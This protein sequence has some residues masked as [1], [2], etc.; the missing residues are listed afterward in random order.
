MYQGKNISVEGYVLGAEVRKDPKIGHIWIMVIGEHPFD[1][2]TNTQLIFP[3]IE[4]KIRVGETGYNSDI[5][6]RCHEASQ[7]LKARGDLVKVYGTVSPA[8][9]MGHYRGIDLDLTAIE[10][11]GSIFDTDYDDRSRFEAKAPSVLKKIIRGGK[12]FTNL[13]KAVI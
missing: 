6:E 12:K 2:G 8:L 7:K 10:I 1:S 11:D 5:M 9:S 3:D 13:L 4:N